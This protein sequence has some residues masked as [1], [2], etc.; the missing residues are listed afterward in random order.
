MARRSAGEMPT[1]GRQLVMG[2]GR[3]MPM[4]GFLDKWSSGEEPSDAGF[5]IA[6]FVPLSPHQIFPAMPHSPTQPLPLHPPTDRF[7]AGTLSSH[8][9][10][11]FF[12]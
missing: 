10:P 3:K 2:V 1:V 4:K 9:L 5:T 11:D 7:S 8:H 6:K 12:R